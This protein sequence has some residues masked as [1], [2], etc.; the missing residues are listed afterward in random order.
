M[1]D[2]SSK[3]DGKFVPNKGKEAEFEAYRQESLDLYA[4]AVVES[5]PAWQKRILAE[6]SDEFV[7]RFESYNSSSNIAKKSSRESSSMPDTSTASN[8]TGMMGTQLPVSQLRTNA[9]L[10]PSGSLSNTAGRAS[11]SANRTAFEKSGF[12]GITSDASVMD[13]ADIFKQAEMLMTRDPDTPIPDLRLD[14]DGTII[15]TTRPAR[16]VFEELDAEGRAIDDLI[17]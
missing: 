3:R 4:Q 13:D 1:R 5:P 14:D 12:T 10:A 7:Q 9:D 16:E 17:T 8:S 6:A 15:G 11:K 2:I